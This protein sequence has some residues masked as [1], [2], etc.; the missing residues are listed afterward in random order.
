M[1]SEPRIPVFMRIGDNDERK[2]GDLDTRD[3]M[4]SLLR[5]AA[6]QFERGLTI[7]EPTTDEET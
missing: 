7:P 4:P 2:I 1:A 3:A 6:D 5:H